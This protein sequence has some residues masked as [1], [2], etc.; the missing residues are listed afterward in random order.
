MGGRGRI[1]QYSFHKSRHIYNN[2]VGYKQA[3]IGLFQ[4][5]L[6]CLQP[7]ISRIFIRSLE[8]TDNNARELDSSTERET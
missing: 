1:L 8:R 2:N 7:F 5:E 4:A 6:D 3:N